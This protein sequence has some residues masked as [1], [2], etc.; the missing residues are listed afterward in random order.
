MFDDDVS[1]IIGEIQSLYV[2]GELVGGVGVHFV[3]LVEYGLQ[4]L[5]SVAGH[6]TQFLRLV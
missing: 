1:R 2:F 6:E 3:D 4:G 5:C